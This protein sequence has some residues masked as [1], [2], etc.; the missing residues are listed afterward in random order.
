MAID[1]GFTRRRF[2]TTASGGI[3]GTT[4]AMG[5]CRRA[6]GT[7]AAAPLAAVRSATPADVQNLVGDARKRRILLRGAVVLS[8]DPTLGDF[9]KADV[10]VDGKTIAQIAPTIAPGGQ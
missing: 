2:L 7:S 8:L 1:P 10:L 4:L 3:A 6:S 9:E 5:S